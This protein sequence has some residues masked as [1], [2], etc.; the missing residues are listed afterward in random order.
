M[1]EVQS[2]ER[3]GEIVLEM[4]AAMLW[5]RDEGAIRVAEICRATGLSSSVIYNHFGSRQGLI[6][7]AVISMYAEASEQTIATMAAHTDSPSSPR[8]SASGTWASWVRRDGPS[9]S[10]CARFACAP[11][12]A[13][14]RESLRDDVAIAQD[15]HLGTLAAYLGG[16]QARGLVG[17]HLSPDRLARVVETYVL[18][19]TYNDIA[20]RPVSNEEWLDTFWALLNP[21]L[22]AEP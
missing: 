17:R 15:R 6:D 16:L 22:V 3:T 5:R 4:T 11:S 19:H 20:L 12:A 7:A 10:A 2:P 13:V 18:G 8:S 21:H 9:G 1:S 14:A